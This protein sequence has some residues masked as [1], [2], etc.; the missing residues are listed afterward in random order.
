MFLEENKGI[1]ENTNGALR[2]A[3]GEY[4][5]LLDHDDAEPDALMRW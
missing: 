3:T 1:S 2:I 4:I 5:G